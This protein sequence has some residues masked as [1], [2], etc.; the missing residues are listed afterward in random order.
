MSY[1]AIKWTIFV[2]LL[3]TVPAILFM[4]QV[5]MFFPAVFFLAGIVFLIPKTLIHFGSYDTLAFLIIF[6][7]HFLI[8][9][10]VYYLVSV[11]TAKLVSII[12][13]DGVKKII[14]GTILAGLVVLTQFPVYVAGGHV[15]MKWLTLSE[16]LGDL[17]NKY[18]K[19]AVI[20]VS[21]ITALLIASFIY[22]RVNTGASKPKA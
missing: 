12:N 19:T 15:P 5:I 17:N 8:Y 7:I 3:L 4:V 6:V 9:F 10:T 13:T 11:I 16:F 2:A 22:W 18:S 20:S 21:A 1:P 14:V